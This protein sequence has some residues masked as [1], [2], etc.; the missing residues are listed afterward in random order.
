VA[1]RSAPFGEPVVAVGRH[2]TFYYA[3]LGADA[4]ARTTIQVNRSTDGGR[5]WSDAVVVQQDNGGDKDWMAVGPDPGS[6]NRDN[7]YVTWKSFQSTGQQLRFGR[8]T[9]RGA[10]GVTKTTFPPSAHP[11]PGPAQH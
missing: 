9:D 10:T 4:S 7:V 3:G 1:G 8:S 2:G 5:T 6:K 11:R